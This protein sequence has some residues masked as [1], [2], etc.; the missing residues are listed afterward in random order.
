MSTAKIIIDSFG[1]VSPPHGYSPDD[2]AE[3]YE[4]GRRDAMA[5]PVAPA[6]DKPATTR[7]QLVNA[8]ND[9]P[10][11]LRINTDLGQLF[12][13]LQAVGDDGPATSGPVATLHDDGYWTA[14]K[15][16][17]GRLLDQ[18]LRNAG[19]RVDVYTAPPDVQRDAELLD[20]LRDALFVHNWNG[21]VGPGC[22]AQWQVA[23]DY[24]SK[25]R[26]LTDE[27][28]TMAGDFRRA[29]TAAMAAKVPT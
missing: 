15:T 21:V 28:G 19:S 23:P 25:Q 17:A 2:M 11:D 5:A 12:K 8:W 9:L 6:G 14:K 20:W 1:T 3:A 27:S 24:R 10:W 18:R 16:E 4:M 22:A 29:I 26:G 13:L 7:T